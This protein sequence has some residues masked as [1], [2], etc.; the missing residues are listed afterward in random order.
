MKLDTLGTQTSEIVA[1]IDILYI[2]G[3]GHCG[4]TLLTLCLDRHPDVIGIGEISTLNQHKPGWSGEH[5]ILQQPFWRKV[6]R[7]YVEGT[8]DAFEEIP[9]NYAGDRL[10][11]HEFPAVDR[12]NFE[13]ARSILSASQRRLIVDASKNVNR[14]RALINSPYF[15]VKVIHLVRDARAHIHAYRRKKVSWAGGF[16]KLLVKEYKIRRLQAQSPQ[17]PWRV[18]RY[19][20]FATSTQA[21]LEEICGFCDIPFTPDLLHPDTAC[22]RGIGGNRLRKRPVEAIRLN[23]SWRNDISPAMLR[24]LTLMTSHYNRR[25]GY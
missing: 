11:R 4:S 23:E 25:Y 17:T 8:G 20:D 21:T 5:D 3:M 16:A 13:A 14:L 6:A 12:A 9:F 1:P 15:N 19:E 10:H 7:D 18:V 24:M 22:F 2:I